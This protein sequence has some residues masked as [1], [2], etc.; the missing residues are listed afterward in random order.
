MFKG[1]I[2]DLDGTV[3]LS[4]RLIPGADRVIR[5]LREIGKKVSYLSNKPIQTREDYASKLTRLGIPTRPEEVVNSTLVM[6]NYLRKNAPSAKVFVV[7]ELPFVDEVKR[8]GFEM[9]ED[10]KEIEY[11]I[12][13]FDR[14]FDYKKLN[15]SF[16][17]IKRGA[18]FVATN[19]DRTCPVEGGEIPDCA[20]MIAAIEAV[21]QEKVE[22]IVGKPNLYMI[23]TALEVMGLRP[24]EC[25]LVGDRLETDIQMG[26][27]SGVST[28]LVL[29]G[30][31]DEK[32]L[33]ESSIQPDFVF[34]S[35]ADVENLIER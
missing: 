2:F 19:P 11:V 4:D 15:I 22:V 21:T 17:A 31:T 9:T 10:P 28:G 30:V 24:E 1:F 8:A 26:K 25:L 32:T 3:Y 23:R 35:I 18:H 16:Q 14:T 34:R 27:N 5:L 13:A 33:K 7:G 6:I 12:V 29:T 20:G